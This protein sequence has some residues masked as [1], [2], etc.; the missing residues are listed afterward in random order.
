MQPVWSWKKYWKRHRRKI[1]DLHYS[2]I[3]SV[4]TDC[5]APVYCPELQVTDIK[6]P[7]PYIKF[8]STFHI[9]GLL[10]IMKP[11]TW[12][13]ECWAVTFKEP[14]C[15]AFCVPLGASCPQTKISSYSTNDQLPCSEAEVHPVD[16]Y[17][18]SM[19]L[20]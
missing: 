19:K 11:Q 7:R 10:L 18:T 14:N 8:C 12:Q 16:A 9:F 1:I 2:S 15:F 17:V 20:I 4:L 5:C 6:N 13:D 3:A